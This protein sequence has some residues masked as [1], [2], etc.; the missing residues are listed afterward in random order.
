MRDDSVRDVEELGQEV[1][2]ISRDEKGETTVGAGQGRVPF[3]K[4]GFQDFEL[5]W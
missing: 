4:R 2:G 3:L 1:A 5:W